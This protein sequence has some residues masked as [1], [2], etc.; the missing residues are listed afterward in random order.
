[1]QLLVQ[2]LVQVV[3]P[4]AWVEQPAAAALR[5][6]RGDVRIERVWQAGS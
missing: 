2:R 5:W 6:V 4:V 3:R 1:M